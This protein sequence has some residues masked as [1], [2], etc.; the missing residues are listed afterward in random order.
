MPL[1]ESNPRVQV[2]LHQRPEHGS[3]RKR[4]GA[5]FGPVSSL[6]ALNSTVDKFAAEIGVTDHALP[7]RRRVGHPA[8]HPRDRLLG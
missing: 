1:R 6:D 5:I 2:R 4:Q 8:L 3:A 7:V